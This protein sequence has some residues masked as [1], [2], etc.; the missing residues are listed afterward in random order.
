MSRARL[1]N[2]LIATGAVLST[3]MST[4]PAFA[5]ACTDACEKERDSCMAQVSKKGGPK[6]QQCVQ[7]LNA[8]KKE[9]QKVTQNPP[10][11][12]IKVGSE[13]GTYCSGTW[14][15]GGWAFN[16]DPAGGD[17]CA[18]IVKTGGTIQ[19]KGLYK[20][21]DTNRVVVRCYPPDYGWVGVY[22]GGGN[23][24]LTAAYNSAT[25]PK[26]LPGCV[27]TASP[28]SMPILDSPFPL[29]AKYQGG[30]Y[31]HVNGFNFARPPYNTLNVADFGQ[32]SSPTSSA[33]TIVDWM[34]RERTKGSHDAHDWKIDRLTP[35][36]AAA[37]G[38][39][40]MARTY[41]CADPAYT[42]PC[43]T[44]TPACPKVVTGMDTTVQQE[45]AIEHTVLRRGVC[46][47]GSGYY[48]KF[49]TYYA[50]LTNFSVSVGQIVEK[51]D[52]IGPSGNTGNSSD[53]HLHFGVI[54]L[55]NTAA[56]PEVTVN[57]LP[58]TAHDDGGDKVIEPYGWAA[59]KGFDPWAWKGYPKGA[60]SPNLWNSGQAPATGDW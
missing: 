50:H 55:T 24:P 32:P 13:Y 60:L 59:P 19:R 18:S 44:K 26:K 37:R 5:D 9:C 11:Q 58:P 48:E 33:A 3:I 14:P 56:Q 15:D 57:W 52:S 41:D 39:V 7:A 36:R 47:S 22:E 21:N 16:S 45:V 10:E 12:C 46:G 1:L 42:C 54:R 23:G 28:R 53:P 34:G 38:K 30:P 49:I 4:P 51:G 2:M 27:F 35:I 6:P 25:T 29:G 40:V 43:G 17:P 31:V 20:N 8:C